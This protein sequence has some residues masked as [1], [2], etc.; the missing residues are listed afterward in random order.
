MSEMETYAPGA[1]SLILPE[2]MIGSGI[3]SGR[4]NNTSSY[5]AF[6]QEVH[7]LMGDSNCSRRMITFAIGR[8]VSAADPSGQ[9]VKLVSGKGVTVVDPSNIANEAQ[10]YVRE[11]GPMVAET[12]GEVVDAL[13][14]PTINPSGIDPYRAPLQPE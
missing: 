7:E 13:R 12:L 2:D 14:R 4:R 9:V 11:C 10:I 8:L 6:K 1:F 3:E 5:Q